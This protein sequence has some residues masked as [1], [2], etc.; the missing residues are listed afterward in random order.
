MDALEARAF[1]LWKVDVTPE[2]KRLIMVELFNLIKRQRNQTD[3]KLYSE[4]KYHCFNVTR[5]EFDCAVASLRLFD[6]IGIY[7]TTLSETGETYNINHK[8][9]N[10]SSVWKK[11]L[12]H[13]KQFQPDAVV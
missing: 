5:V 1:A 13:I 7:K 3:T 8:R 10:M 12:K 4:L 11:Y 2:Y 6:V 9:Q